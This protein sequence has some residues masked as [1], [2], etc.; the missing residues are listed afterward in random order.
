MMNTS[1]LDFCCTSSWT[2][3]PSIQCRHS[4][5]QI[6]PPCFAKRPNR[7]G[8][9]L[10]HLDLDHQEEPLIQ[11]AMVTRVVRCAKLENGLRERKKRNLSEKEPE[12]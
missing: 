4:C 10:K 5:T 12:D 1:Y 11:K 7:F 3:V 2:L 6:L 9:V 8:G